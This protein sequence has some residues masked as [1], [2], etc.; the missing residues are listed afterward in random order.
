MNVHSLVPET[1][2]SANSAILAGAPD[3]IRTCDLPSRSRTLYPLSYKRESL[4]FYYYNT[5]TSKRQEE[6]NQNVQ[7]RICSPDSSV[8]KMP[9]YTSSTDDS[10][11]SKIQIMPPLPSL[12]MRESVS[13]VLFCAS[14]GMRISFPAN[15]SRTRSCKDFPKISVLQSF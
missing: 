13:R 8:I 3:R 1:S 7:H 10:D 6:N 14:S 2:A 11:Y 4:V 12:M 5:A 9:T 15:P